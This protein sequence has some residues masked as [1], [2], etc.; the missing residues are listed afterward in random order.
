MLVFDELKHEY[1]HKGNVVPSVTQIL[2]GAGLIDLSMVKEGVLEYRKQLGTAVHRATELYDNNDLVME[3]LDP[4]IKP[5]LDGWIKF[6]AEV[7]FGVEA[8]E[9]RLFHPKYQ[10]AGTLDRVGTIFGKRSLVDLKTG[11]VYA[12]YGAQTAAYKEAYEFEHKKKIQA[13]YTLQLKDDGSYKLE[14][15]N[16]KNDWSVFLACLTLNNFKRNYQ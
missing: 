16:N 7:D 5:Y 15:M 4:R 6:R 10:Y 3:D 11:L 1:R 14:P 12:S 2:Q 13:R 8:N 9:L